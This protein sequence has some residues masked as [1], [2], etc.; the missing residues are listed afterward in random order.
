[1]GGEPVADCGQHTL[2]VLVVSLRQAEH[3]GDVQQTGDHLLLGLGPEPE[4][5]AIVQCVLVG[6]FQRNL[7][8][9]HSPQPT[10][11]R[12]LDESDCRAYP[13]LAVQGVQ[14][15]FATGE[16]RIARQWH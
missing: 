4:D 10:E 15:R 5:P 11:R 16:V 14:D 13:Q 12:G 2:L 8:L 6:I 3:R 1:M 9:A 7:R